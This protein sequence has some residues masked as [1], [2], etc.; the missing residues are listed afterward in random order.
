MREVTY[1]PV[2][3]SFL[4]LTAD[5]LGTSPIHRAVYV[6][7]NFMGIHP[8]PP[9]ANVKIEEPDVLEVDVVRERRAA[10]AIRPLGPLGPGLAGAIVVEGPEPIE[11]DF[12]EP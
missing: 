7:E 3:G 9:P 2:M 8:S 4:T 11:V 10:R 1:S 6:M 5:S 12:H